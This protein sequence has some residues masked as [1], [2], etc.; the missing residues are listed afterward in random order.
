VFAVLQSA[1]EGTSENLHMAHDMRIF[2]GSLEFC[3]SYNYSK[4]EIADAV[5][6]LQETGENP[7]FFVN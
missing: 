3:I 4:V 6:V 1:L 7:T 5:G 2:R